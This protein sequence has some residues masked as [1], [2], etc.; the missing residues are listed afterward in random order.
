LHRGI[1]VPRRISRAEATEMGMR[2]LISEYSARPPASTTSWK[3]RGIRV[4]FVQ[5]WQL[6]AI[7][8]PVRLR[9]K[10]AR[11]RQSRQ[12]RSGQ[13]M[14]S[15]GEGEWLHK[16]FHSAVRACLAAG[17]PDVA[18]QATFASLRADHWTRLGDVTPEDAY[19]LHLN[20]RSATRISLA[21]RFGGRQRHDIPF[22]GATLFDL[23][24]LPM[25][26][27]EGR[28]DMMRVYLPRQRMISVAET[29]ARRSDVRLRLPNPGFDDYIIASLLNIIDF[30]FEKPAQ[31]SQL[32]V[33]EVSVALMSHLIHNYSDASPIE[34]SRG[35]LAP[36]QER[37]AKEI[38]FARIRNPPTVDELAQACG[39]S[40]RHF[41]RAFAHSTGRT[42]H[43][44]L[45]QERAVEA[46]NLLE[47][48]DSTLAEISA[49]CGYANQ[50]H[51]CRSFLRH[52][53]KSPSTARRQAKASVASR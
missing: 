30:A 17:L 29:M 6:C 35:G 7:L 43:Q 27:V 32:F 51:F 47:H 24:D 22:R 48:S 41:I 8:Q 2:S 16:R 36:W 40:A 25:V 28:Y 14:Q 23:S 38:L 44:W 12:L 5:R 31:A 9:C 19:T 39:V 49:L 11:G 18:P 13:S 52:F 4:A 53:G 21:G 15:S 1:A 46:K 42:P 10:L 3:A 34:R 37:I 26:E 33:D 20:R 50:S 45:M